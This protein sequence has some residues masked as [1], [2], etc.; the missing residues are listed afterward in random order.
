MADR[1]VIIADG[2]HRY[3]TA[4][5]Y[6]R[7]H[8]RLRAKLM[9]F[10]ALEAPGLTILPNHRLVHG[11]ARFS[12]AGLVEAARPWFDA[13]PLVDPAA[14][15]PTNRSPGVVTAE[16]AVTLT[17]RDDDAFE[18]VAWPPTTSRAWRG[19]AVSILH[20]A[21]LKPL[22]DITDVR[23]DAGTHVA[24]S[25]DQAEAVRVARSGQYQAAF[26]IAPTTPSELAA[27]VQGGEILP[28]KS[29]HFYPKLLDGLVFYRPA[30][31]T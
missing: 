3:E 30:E 27:V 2:H 8:P 15:R 22:L 12:L 23:L 10:F 7:Q 16:G 31:G 29:T 9:A 24:Y 21:I 20:E 5:D 28:Q 19:L 14:H 26:L 1:T 11:V 18:R 13:A 4:V 6:A 17:L 25:A